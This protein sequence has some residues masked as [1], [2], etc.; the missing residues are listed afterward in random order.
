MEGKA[1][2]LRLEAAE[3]VTP[4]SGFGGWDDEK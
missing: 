4:K 1:W 3:P 2:A